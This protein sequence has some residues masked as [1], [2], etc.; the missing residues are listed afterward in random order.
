[1]LKRILATLALATI[2][3]GPTAVPATAA[4]SLHA[5]HVD[6]QQA[7]RV[8]LYRAWYYRRYGLYPSAQVIRAWYYRTYGVYPS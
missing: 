8:S 5:P 4:F 7:R 3:L 1:M 2:A 6:A